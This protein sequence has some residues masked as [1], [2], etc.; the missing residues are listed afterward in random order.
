MSDMEWVDVVA[1]A[2]EPVLDDNGRY[3]CTVA[4]DIPRNVKTLH[5]GL[6]TDSRIDFANVTEREPVTLWMVRRFLDNN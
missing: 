3:L 1:R 5:A 6:F 2:G 4:A